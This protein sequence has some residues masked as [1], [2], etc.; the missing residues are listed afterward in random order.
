MFAGINAVIIRRRQRYIQMENK[1]ERLPTD[2]RFSLIKAYQ[3]YQSGDSSAY[4]VFA[5]IC[6]EN[7]IETEDFIF[8]WEY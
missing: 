4:R 2:T 3:D 7:N 8:W 5:D 6:E 1:I